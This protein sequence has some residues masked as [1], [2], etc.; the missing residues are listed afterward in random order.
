M[1]IVR[2]HCGAVLRDAGQGGGPQG[3]GTTLEGLARLRNRTPPAMPFIDEGGGRNCGF[4]VHPHRKAVEG[5]GATTT[6]IRIAPEGA[7]NVPQGFIRH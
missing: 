4:T 3:E 1:R 2:G 7:F 6:Q 5:T